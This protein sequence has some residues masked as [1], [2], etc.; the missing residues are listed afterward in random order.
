MGRLAARTCLDELAR[1]LPLRAQIQAFWLQP[2]HRQVDTWLEHANINDVM[3][4]TCLRPEGLL[5]ITPHHT[6]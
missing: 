2:E 3:L 5:F 6:G 1:Y 4:A